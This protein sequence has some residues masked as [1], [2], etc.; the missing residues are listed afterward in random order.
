MCWG[1]GG[2]W[3]RV[4]G[5]REKAQDERE[6]NPSAGHQEAEGVKEGDRPEKH[7]GEEGGNKSR[8]FVIWVLVLQYS[9]PA[10]VQQRPGRGGNP[11]VHPRQEVELG[12]S[13][14]LVSL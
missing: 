14:R 6:Y 8:R 11:T 3:G 4:E 13:A 7:W 10:E 9:V 5:G 2:E 12:D 1:G